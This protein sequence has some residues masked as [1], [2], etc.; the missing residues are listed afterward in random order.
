M[1]LRQLL[2]NPKAGLNAVDELGEPAIM[3]AYKKEVHFEFTF[4]HDGANIN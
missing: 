4:L 3:Q 1:K 2:S